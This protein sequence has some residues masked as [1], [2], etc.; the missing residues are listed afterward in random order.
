VV[1]PRS[2]RRDHDIFAKWRKR[3]TDELFIR[4]RTVYLRRIEE[5]HSALDRRA[6]ELKTLPPV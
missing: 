1:F 2:L 6:N 4:K 3:F 5:S